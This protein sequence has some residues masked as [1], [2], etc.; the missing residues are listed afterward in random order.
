[1]RVAA[2]LTA[3]HKNPTADLNRYLL[4]E[5]KPIV[6]DAPLVERFDLDWFAIGFGEP[7]LSCTIADRSHGR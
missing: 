4:A 2:S 5:H 1:L 6:P 7:R 3:T